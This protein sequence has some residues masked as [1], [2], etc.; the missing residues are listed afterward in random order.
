MQTFNINE[1]RTHL[2]SLVDRAANGESFVISKA[3]KPM[4]KVMALEVP[5]LPKIKRIG[6][7]VGQVTVPE[8]KVFNSLGNEEIA[9]MFGGDE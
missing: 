2:S 3:G 8:A 9:T 4:V 1:A 5:A 6:F 7:L